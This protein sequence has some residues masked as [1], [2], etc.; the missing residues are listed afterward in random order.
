MTDFKRVIAHLVVALLVFSG[1]SMAEEPRELS[2][3][4]LIPEAKTI[5]GPGGDNPVV[6]KNWNGSF[7]DAFSTPVLPVGVVEE[8][9]GVLAKIPGFVV[10][11]ELAEGGK[12]KE[13]LLVPYF[14]A[15]IHYP[16]P[17]P[18]QLVHVT[19][20][21]PTEIQ[22][23]WDPIWAIGKLKTEMKRSDLGSAGYA[24]VAQSLEIYEY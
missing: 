5:E 8:L 23:Q 16:P 20:D 3:D 13:F 19:M 7:E 15:C 6:G 18:N 4:D 2:W 10:P 24:M 1:T 9:D 14:G 11:L 21:E 17:P 22:S 12:V